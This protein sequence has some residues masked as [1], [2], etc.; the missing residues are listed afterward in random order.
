MQSRLSNLV[1]LADEVEAVRVVL[2][3]LV[4]EAA[5]DGALLLLRSGEI[6]VAQVEAGFGQLETLGAL[7]VGSFASA[8]EIARLLG[9]GGC[10]SQFQQGSGR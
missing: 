8:R 1:L 5:A 3:R 10:E 4:D 6:A 2:S 7:L 9:E